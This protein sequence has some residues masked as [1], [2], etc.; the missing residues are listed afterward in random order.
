MRSG[1]MRCVIII[2]FTQKKHDFVWWMNFSFNDRIIT[3][4]IFGKLVW[5]WKC[6]SLPRLQ[7]PKHTYAFQLIFANFI[8]WPSEQNKKN[9]LTFRN[10]EN[11]FTFEIWIEKVNRMK[12]NLTFPIPTCRFFTSLLLST[13]FSIIFDF[14]WEIKYTK[15]YCLWD[16]LHLNRKAES[17]QLHQGVTS[18]LVLGH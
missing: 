5:H 11:V 14:C 1:L 3:A 10:Y 15:V 13:S 17:D 6:Q 16:S 8:L 9:G 18:Q 2:G 7:V 4:C 12:I